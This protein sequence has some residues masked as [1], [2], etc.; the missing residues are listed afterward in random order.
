[1]KK[2]RILLAATLGCALASPM[3][4]AASPAAD[5]AGEELRAVLKKHHEAL[6]KQDIKALMA[7]YADTPEVALMGTGMGEFWKGKA[8]VEGAYKHYFETFKAGSLSHECPEAAGNEEGNH[9]W[10]MASCVMKDSDPAGKPRE[11]GL[12]VSAV[13]KKEAS[14][15]KF[16]A[17]HVSNL[18]GDGGAPP[19]GAAAP[20]AA[21]KKA[22]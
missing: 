2:Y 16:E 13:L 18:A 5:K 14:G 22:E 6:N 17:V 1:M 7:L 20:A 10:L 8:D 21:P 12:N 19:E 4:L 15:W 11:F 3:V 9:A